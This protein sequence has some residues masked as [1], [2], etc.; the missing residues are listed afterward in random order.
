[1]LGYILPLDATPTQVLRVGES[2][3]GMRPPGS[4]EF[5]GLRAHHG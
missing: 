3:G 4:F 2:L 1:M 5:F